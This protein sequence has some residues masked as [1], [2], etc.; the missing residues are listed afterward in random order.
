MPP[1]SE[2]LIW[3]RWIS[4]AENFEN[5]T[6][7]YEIAASEGIDAPRFTLTQIPE[8]LGTQA[9]STERWYFDPNAELRLKA[10]D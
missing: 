4:F 3:P 7:Y 9:W 6:R 1:Q 8:G 10:V 5:F 2:R